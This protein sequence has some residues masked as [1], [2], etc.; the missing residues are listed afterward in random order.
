MQKFTEILKKHKFDVKPQENQLT[1]LKT[2]ES[3]IIDDKKIGAQQEKKLFED[4]MK[5]KKKI[6]GDHLY[7]RDDSQVNSTI[8]TASSQKT[9]YYQKLVRSMGKMGNKSLDIDEENEIY[10]NDMFKQYLTPKSIMS[11]VQV[12]RSASEWSAG[13]RKTE[14]S[15]LQGYYQLIEN[16]KHY[17]YIENQFFVSKSWT[18]EEKK[19]CKPRLCYLLQKHA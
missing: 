18:E 19:K 16:S 7:V 1:K 8:T 15:I 10:K 5:G 4:F 9:S 11:C 6:D 14:N 12:L 17:I 13:L 3:I 2:V